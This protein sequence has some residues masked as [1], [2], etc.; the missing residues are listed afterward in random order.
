MLKINEVT[1]EIPSITNLF[2]TTT[3]LNTKINEVKNKIT[4]ITNLVTATALTAV[5]N[6]IPSVGNLV[7]KS[8][9]NI[10]TSEIE[11][12]ITDH[13]CDKYITTP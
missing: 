4:N 6:K 1:G 10:K 5:E 13:D 8:D 3:A 9:Y 2:R 11:K 12:K 7:K